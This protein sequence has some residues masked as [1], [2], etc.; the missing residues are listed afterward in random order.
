M[1]HMRNNE[2]FLGYLNCVADEL[3]EAT[4]EGWESTE[5]YEFML[6]AWQQ[7]KVYRT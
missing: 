2:T 1:G 7:K 5:H 4:Q 3:G 6:I